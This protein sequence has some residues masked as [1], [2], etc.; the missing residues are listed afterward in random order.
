MFPATNARLSDRLPDHLYDHIIATQSANDVVHHMATFPVHAGRTGGSLEEVVRAWLVVREVFA[1]AE[2]FRRIE[3]L[4]GDAD[5]RDA[6]MLAVMRLGRCGP[7]VSCVIVAISRS[8]GAARAV[9]GARREA[10][11]GCAWVARRLEGRSGP[12][13]PVA[14]G[15]RRTSPRG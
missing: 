6:L 14:A 12:A 7:L 8:R 11:S 9:P 1:I 3:T 13:A 5:T 2:R 10:R 15:G 4:Q